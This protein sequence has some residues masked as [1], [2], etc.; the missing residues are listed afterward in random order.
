MNIIVSNKYEAL[1][2]TIEIDRLQEINGTYSVED[3]ASTFKTTFYNKMIIDI[4]AIKDYKNIASIQKLIL[5]FPVDKIILLLDDSREVNDPVYLSQLVSMGIYNFTLDIKQV[6]YL[7]SNPNTY[8]D[9]AQYHMLGLTKEEIEKSKEAQEQ[10]SK[11][12]QQKIIGIVNVTSHAGAT[13]LSYLLMKHL[14]NLYRVKAVELNESD[15]VFFKEENLDSIQEEN[16]KEYIENNASL[17]AI[18]VDLNNASDE[19]K[20]LCTDII[21]LVEP[22]IIQLNKVMQKDRLTFENLYDKKLVLN[23]SILNNKDVEDF[24]RETGCK[25]FFNIPSVDD[26]LDSI[27]PIKRFLSAL[28]FTRFSNEDKILGFSL[29]K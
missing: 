8:K 7:I 16:L 17:E 27:K 21:Y 26:K 14:L 3:L 19:T 6:P 10:A 28:G 5:V 15:F 18:I 24:E 23:R 1:L 13:T 25:V 20:R 4:T 12:A 11:L 9:V 29:F 2:H 22:G